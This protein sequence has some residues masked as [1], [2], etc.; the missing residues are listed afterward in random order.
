MDLFIKQKWTHRHRGKKT[1]Q[2]YVPQRGRT[3][4][5]KLGI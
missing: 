4:R 2:T 3:E 1:K 5:D